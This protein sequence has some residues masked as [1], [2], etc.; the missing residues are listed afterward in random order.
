MWW[1]F[2]FSIWNIFKLTDITYNSIFLVPPKKH[3]NLAII[4]LPYPTQLSQMVYH[5]TSVGVQI[6]QYSTSLPPLPIV[7]YLISFTC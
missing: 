2:F 1:V 6:L 7:S 3:E 5:I 4:D